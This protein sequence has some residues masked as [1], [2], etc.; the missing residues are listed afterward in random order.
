MTGKRMPNEIAQLVYFHHQTGKSVKEIAD[1]LSLRARTVYNIIYRAEKE[2]RLERNYS[3]G[4]PKT[5]IGIEAKIAKILIVKPEL[6]TRRLAR[7][8]E[9]DYG[10]KVSHETVRRIRIKLINSKSTIG[11]KE[12]PSSPQQSSPP[13][14]QRRCENYQEDS[15]RS[16]PCSPQDSSNSWYNVNFSSAI[17]T[18]MMLHYQP[19]INIKVGPQEMSSIRMDPQGMYIEEEP[20]DIN[21]KKKPQEMGIKM[22]PK[23]MYVKKESLEINVKQEAQKMSNKMEPLGMIIMEQPQ[24]LIIKMEAK[25]INIKVEPHTINVKVEP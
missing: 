5:L 11:G 2:Q 12:Q 6:S 8:L 1:M 4:R 14:R 24:N 3:P 23:D 7:Q 21:I 10:L 19:Y 22:D 13:T 9:S 20:L 18:K 16:S 17:M 15:S 25:D